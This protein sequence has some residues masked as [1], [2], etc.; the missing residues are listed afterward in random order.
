M[1]VLMAKGIGPGDAV[2]CPSFTFCATAEVVVLLGAT[3]VFADI[4]AETFNIDTASLRRGARHRQGAGP[5]ADARSSRSIC[6]DCRPTTTPS[7]RSRR[8]RDCSCSTMPRRASAPRTRAARSAPSAPA[9]ATSFF[10]A[11]PLGCYGDGG[12][13]LTDD[14][15]LERYAAQPARPWPGHRQ[16]RQRADRHDQPA[17]HDAGGGAD[18]KA[19]DLPRGDRGAQPGRAALCRGARRCLLS[20]RACRTA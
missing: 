3:P 12:A 7:P 4:E 17:R 18:R 20:F 11:K 8:P 9:T 14:D 15:E 1:L 13:V 2:I 6:S 16:I 5:Q 19:Q 10:P